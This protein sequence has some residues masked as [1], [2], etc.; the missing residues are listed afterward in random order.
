M[1]FDPKGITTF[2]TNTNGNAGGGQVYDVM[3][4]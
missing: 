2:Y 1:G 4:I 3:K